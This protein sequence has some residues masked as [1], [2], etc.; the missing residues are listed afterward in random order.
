M[1]RHRATGWA[2]D[3][4]LGARL[5]FAGGR[6]GLLRTLMTAVG[7]GLGVALLLTSTS[8]STM[9]DGRSE[10]NAARDD[11][12]FG[13]AQPAPGD[14]TLLVTAADT[15]YRDQVIRGRL[16]QPDGAHPPV[17]PGLARLPGPGE[18]VVSPH[19]PGC[20]TRPT[21]H[22]SG[23]GWTTPSSAP[24]PTGVSPGPTSTP[25]TSAPTSSG[26]AAPRCGST[27]SVPSR[28][29]RGSTPC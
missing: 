22:C 13:S 1:S 18:L 25:T 24:S 10:R 28:A 3:L 29:A 12:F 21:G 14:R 16:L 7:V 2:A 27:T 19:W 9:L 6:N 20:S 15:V 4:A 5:V 17:P 23:P 8:V 26:R 11:Q